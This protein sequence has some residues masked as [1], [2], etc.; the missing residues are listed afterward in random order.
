MSSATTELRTYSELAPGDILANIHGL[1]L[2]RVLEVRTIPTT[3]WGDT[4]ELVEERISNGE[5]ET[6][7]GNL[8][9][10]TRVYIGEDA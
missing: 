6:S 10:Q 8:R 2:M 7:T 1:P 3:R 5:V 4:I 9:T